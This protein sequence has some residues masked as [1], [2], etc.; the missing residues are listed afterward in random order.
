MLQQHLV[1]HID[2]TG[3]HQWKTV[4]PIQT[5]H[6]IGKPPAGSMNPVAVGETVAEYGLKGVDTQ[7]EA[8]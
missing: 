8:Q 5:R 2:P 7:D 6:P 1:D 3:G 4:F